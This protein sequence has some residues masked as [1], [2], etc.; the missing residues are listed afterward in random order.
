VCKAVNSGND[1]H[2]AQIHASEGSATMGARSLIVGRCQTP[3]CLRRHRAGL[4]V[5]VG[6]HLRR[7]E[8]PH[9]GRRRTAYATDHECVGAKRW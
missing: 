3:L 6:L 4:E 5:Q 2:S 8:S 7:L 9:R 1:L